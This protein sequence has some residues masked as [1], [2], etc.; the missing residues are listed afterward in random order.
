MVTRKASYKGNM[1][2][3]AAFTWQVVGS[4]ACKAKILFDKQEN[5]LRICQ[6]HDKTFA[7]FNSNESFL[8]FYSGELQV[9]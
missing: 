3:K 2:L 6:R 1:T 5:K 4:V 9:R 7:G 8:G